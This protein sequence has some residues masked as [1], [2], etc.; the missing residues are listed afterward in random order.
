MKRLSRAAALAAGIVLAG[1]APAGPKPG[2]ARVPTPVASEFNIRRD[3]A[4]VLIVGMAEPLPGAGGARIGFYISCERETGRLTATFSFGAFPRGKIV[5]GAVRHPDGRVVRVGSAV[6]GGSRAGFHSPLTEDRSTVLR[7]MDAV[8]IHGALVS[9]GH[10]SIWNR[11]AEAENRAVR[12]ELLA[13]AG[14]RD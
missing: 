12:T 6:R 13:C 10:N 9:N 1:L 14:A 5:H 4:D 2:L 11:A 8:L 7:L 3:N